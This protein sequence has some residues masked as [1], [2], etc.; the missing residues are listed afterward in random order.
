MG[1]IDDL[2][3]GYSNDERT[4]HFLSELNPDGPEMSF[5]Y[6]HPLSIFPLWEGP[7]PLSVIKDI[8]K[9]AGLEMYVDEG[10]INVVSGSFIGAIRYKYLWYRKYLNTWKSFYLAIVRS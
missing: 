6:R 10:E 3:C 8:L 9:E 4:Q 1:I 5:G 2:Q 7:D